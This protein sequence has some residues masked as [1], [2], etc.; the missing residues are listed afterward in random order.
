MDVLELYEPCGRVVTVNR[1]RPKG[2]TKSDVV[3]RGKAFEIIG[4]KARLR[5]IAKC[6][7]IEIQW[8]GG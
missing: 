7:K 1:I 2:Y 4:A 5:N 8:R 6:G 3:N